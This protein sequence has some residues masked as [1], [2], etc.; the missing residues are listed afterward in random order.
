[1]RFFDTDWV[2]VF[3]WLAVWEKLSVPARRHYLLAQQSH[4]ATVSAEGY[5]SEKELV[6][7]VGLVEA[8]STGRFKP[9]QASVPFRAL[10]AQLAKFPL[11][12]QKPTRQLLDEY[13]AKHYLREEND[14]IRSSGR[15][16]AWDSQ[17][18]L[19]SFLDQS[20][21]KAWEKGYLTYFELEGENRSS[22]FSIREPARPPDRKSVV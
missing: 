16:P 15:G 4:A 11:F 9:T 10:M 19:Q 7:E 5:G 3:R 20:K 13:A 2:C 22:W 17:A 6:L 18:W 21:L 14:Y 8:I 12:D 1:M